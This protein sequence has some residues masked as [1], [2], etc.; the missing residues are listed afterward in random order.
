MTITYTP[1][2]MD[3][4]TLPPPQPVREYMSTPC[5]KCNHTE[6]ITVKHVTSKLSSMVRE[7]VCT[8]EIVCNITDTDLAELLQNIAKFMAIEDY[9]FVRH[10]PEEAK[11][12]ERF[13]DT[14]DGGDSKQKFVAA[15]KSDRLRETEV[16]S[17]PEERGV[18][19][20]DRL[21]AGATTPKKTKLEIR[22][23]KLDAVLA[24]QRLTT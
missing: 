4:I 11:R 13:I 16:P 12:A 14:A 6:P 24:R 2:A 8:Q 1:L 3:A 10:S 22:Q 20:L 7:S 9:Y 23:A 17:T 5:A 21:Q 19:R 18:N 15:F